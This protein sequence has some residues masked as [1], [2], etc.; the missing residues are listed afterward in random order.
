MSCKLWVRTVQEVCMYAIIDGGGKQVKVTAGDIIKIERLGRDTGS[1][2]EWSPLL[3]VDGETVWSPGLKGSYMVKGK[4]L[5]EGRRRKVLVFHKKRR[6]QY[7]K[8]R[9]HRQDYTQVE[10]LSIAKA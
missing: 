3:V 10:I 2:V 5:G 8:L 4:V 6:K 7:K 9:G 1:E